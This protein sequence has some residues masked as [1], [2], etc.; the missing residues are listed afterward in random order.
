MR[1]ERTKF[2]QKTFSVKEIQDLLPKLECPREDA[3]KIGESIGMTRHA[4]DTLRSLLGFTQKTPDIIPEETMDRVVEI[5]QDNPD[6][7]AYELFREYN[8]ELKLAC[9]QKFY[10]ILRRRGIECNRKRDYWSVFKDKKLLDLRDNK[11][12]SFP[13]I[14]KMMPER[15]IGALQLRHAKLHGYIA[16]SKRNKINENEA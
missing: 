8:G 7:S 3:M 11:K 5:F 12:M 15:S 6:K 14:H 16:P 2:G 4:I 9:Y 1:K 10:E 13:E